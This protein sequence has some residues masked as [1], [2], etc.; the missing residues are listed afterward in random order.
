MLSVAHTPS[1]AAYSP[2][3]P[4]LLENP[5][6]TKHR[7]II[8]PVY[9]NLRVYGR[10]YEPRINPSPPRNRRIMDRKPATESTVAQGVQQS[11]ELSFP[12]QKV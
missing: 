3:K 8:F 11:E 5:R 9:E 10:E 6:R 12:D 2:H 1:L 7:R 4:Q